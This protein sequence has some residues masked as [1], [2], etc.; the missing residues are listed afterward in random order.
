MNDGVLRADWPVPA[1]IVAGTTLRGGDESDLPAEPVWLTQV[2]GSQ[3]VKLGSDDFVAK[4]EA[5][6]VIGDQ[7]GDLCVIRTADCLPILLCASDGSE[8]AAIHAGWRGLAAGVI[9]ATL[10][11]LASRP[12]ELLAWIGPAIAQPSFEVGAE[13][14]EAFAD[15]G[16]DAEGRFLRNDRGRWQADLFGLAADRLQTIGVTSV[17]GE[18]VCTFEDSK[19]FFSFRRDGPTGRLLSFVYLG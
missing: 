8:I 4:P 11:R 2:H 12:S 10:A 18:R 17:Y 16:F 19:R 1:N 14:R 9:D 7:V 5:D 3:V 6:A 13:V 15:A